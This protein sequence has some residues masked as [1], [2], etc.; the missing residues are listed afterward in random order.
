MKKLLALFSLMFLITLVWSPIP[1]YAQDEETQEEVAEPK[2]QEGE[3][4]ASEEGKTEEAEPEEK[5][6]VCPECGF[7]TDEPTGCPACNVPLIEKKEETGDEEDQ[8]EKPAKEEG[9]SDEQGSEDEEPQEKEP[10]P[11]PTEDEE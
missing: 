1:A 10:E 8:E 6:Y 9:S 7:E 4:P 11:E 3:E 2:A 5:V